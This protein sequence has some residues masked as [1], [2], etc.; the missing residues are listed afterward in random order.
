MTTATA[1]TTIDQGF[2]GKRAVV[3]GGTQGLGAAVV[4]GLEAAGARVVVAARSVP[5][6]PPSLFV[7]AD[8]S[9][10]EGAAKVATEAVDLLGGGVDLVFHVAGGSSAPTGG[11]LAIDDDHWAADLD[12]NLMAAVR[13]DRAL[14]PALLEQ[15]SGVIV[16]VTSITNAMPNGTTIAYA[17]AKAGLR[18]YSKALSNE[19][20]PKGIRVVAV[21]PGGIATDAAKRLVARMADDAGT[22][23]ETAR[24]SLMSTLGTVPL[25]RFA[26]PEEVAAVVLFAASAQ[27]AA[28]IGTEITVDGGT[29]PTV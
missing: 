16:H 19:L 15:G 27:A 20:A 22:D 13:L 10:A 7:Q 14:L 26:E 18:T 1:Y 23:H 17:A 11:I 2:A 25:G 12:L 8:V 6:D 24:Q 4:A 29:V 28:V 21:S 9:T 5:A 3:T